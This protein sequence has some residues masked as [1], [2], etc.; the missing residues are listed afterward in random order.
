MRRQNI[1]GQPNKRFSDQ[2]TPV[3]SC[4]GEILYTIQNP[5]FL[6]GRTGNEKHILTLNMT[7]PH[8]F[9]KGK[10]LLTIYVYLFGYK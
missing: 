10:L 1:C 6:W 8:K 4:D 5:T 3:K 2:P 9:V 7:D